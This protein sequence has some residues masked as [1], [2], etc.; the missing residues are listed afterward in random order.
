[1]AQLG[2]IARASRV[3]LTKYG[4]DATLRGVSAGKVA[5]FRDFADAPARL[6]DA[7][8]NHGTSIDV[9]VIGSE[10]APK[11]GD[12][13]V[14]PNGTFKLDRK[15]DDNGYVRHFIVVAA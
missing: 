3:A 14:H 10:F 9:A 7:N 2:Y 13:L 4:Q 1:M 12:T 8:D 15:I 6:D 11:T 5:I